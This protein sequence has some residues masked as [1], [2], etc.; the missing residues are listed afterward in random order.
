MM[1]DRLPH[2][3]LR[4]ASLCAALFASACSAATSPAAKPPDGLQAVDLQI[5][6]TWTQGALLHGKVKPGCGIEF[7]GNKVYVDERGEFIL[8]LGRDAPP[9]VD[10]IVTG[11][12]QA[13]TVHSFAVAQRQYVIQR[14]EG[15]EEKFVTPSAEDLVRIEHDNQMLAAARSLHDARED[16]ANGFTWPLHGP[17]TGVYGSQRFFNGVPKQPHYGLDISA[18]TG[19]P[20]HAP[21]GGKVTLAKDLYYSG[22]TLLID[23]GQGLSSAFLHLSRILVK[24]GDTV[25]QGDLIGEV[26]A[27]GRV[28]A[29]HLDWRMNWL[30]QRLDVQLLLPP[31]QE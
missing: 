14:V 10:V 1:I 30:D 19:T 20:V 6:G 13:R 8:G 28:T 3:F 11:P 16:F 4:A 5:K 27:T 2:T 7:L 31:Q 12:E 25:K 29:S 21:A 18:P 9:Q 22:W 17:I 15:V 23:H 26:G 24:E